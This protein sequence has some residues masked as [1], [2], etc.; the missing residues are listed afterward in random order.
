[1]SQ[2]FVQEPMV[3]R[4]EGKVTFPEGTRVYQLVVPPGVMFD[5][6]C[7]P[8]GVLVEGVEA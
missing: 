8:D 5:P 3:V 1:M 6:A 4:I 2:A 7:L